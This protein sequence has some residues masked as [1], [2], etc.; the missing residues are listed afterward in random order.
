MTAYITKD[1]GK[2]EHFAT[3]MQRDSQENKG[4]F[5][6]IPY[7]AL[8]RVAQLY[9]RGAEKYAA[10]NW[11]KGQPFSRAANSMLRHAAQAANG[12]DDEDHFAAV[13]FNAAAIIAYQERIKT[14]ELPPELDDLPKPGKAIT[15]DSTYGA[16]YAHA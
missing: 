14:G 2:R 8:L 12:F 1:S 6:L 4:R 15:D 11:E 9:E 5:D 3:G 13:I 16:E 10:R 7:E